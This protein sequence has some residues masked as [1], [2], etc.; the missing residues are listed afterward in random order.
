VIVVH[1]LSTILWQHKN[2]ILF[3]EGKKKNEK[4]MGKKGEISSKSAGNIFVHFF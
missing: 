4:A 1:F 2:R 3:G